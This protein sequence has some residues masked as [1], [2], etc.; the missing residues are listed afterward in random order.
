MWPA[1]SWKGPFQ[2]LAHGEYR[3]GVSE[4]WCR[5]REPGR[6]CPV[7]CPLVPTPG[8]AQPLAAVVSTPGL[9]GGCAGAC[10]GLGL[11]PRR[12]E[13]LRCSQ[14]P[15]APVGQVF[16]VHGR[17]HSLTGYHRAQEP[18]AACTACR[19]PYTATSVT[20]STFVC[21]VPFTQ[22]PRVSCYAESWAFYI[23][24]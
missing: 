5:C 20:A 23:F 22:S 16:S 21:L 4:Q 8:L 9:P 24:L 1:G 6:H 19:S 11:A 18:K 17:T 15:Q 10:D 3:I 12:L 14:T 2:Q 13:P 7:S